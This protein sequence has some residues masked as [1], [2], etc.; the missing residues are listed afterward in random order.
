M[1][2]SLGGSGITIAGRCWARV[3]AMERWKEGM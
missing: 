3:C 1:R 2:E